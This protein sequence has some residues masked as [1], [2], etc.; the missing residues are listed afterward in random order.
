MVTVTRK[1]ERFYVPTSRIGS[2]IDAISMIARPKSF[3]TDY[4]E[5]LYLNNAEHEVPFG[6]SIKARRYS[7]MHWDSQVQLD[8]NT[9]WL[10]E[11][12]RELVSGSS[13]LREKEREKLILS[14]ILEK[15]KT[16]NR[17]GNVPVTSPLVPY[18]ADN[19]RRRHFE[20][21]G[22][23]EF[24]ITVDDALKYFFF[25]SGLNG[26][27]I[28]KEDYS[29]VEIK[30]PKEKMGSLEL[31][32]IQSQLDKLEAEPVISKKDMAHN[33]LSDYLR[34]KSN[35]PVN[36]SDTEI[37]SKLILGDESQHVFHQIKR[38]FH[39]GVIDGYSILE[40]FPFTLEA[41][42]LH[43]YVITPD[44]RYLRISMKGDKKKVISKTDSEI[45]E[46]SYGLNCILK[47]TEVREEFSPD[48]LSLPSR[49]I[50]RK[51]KYFLVE[52]K[53]TG[54]TYC[55]LIDRSTLDGQTMFQMEVEGT[56]LSPSPSEVKATVE[57][58]AY[59]TKSIVNRY[60]NL[61]PTTLAKLD[62]LRKTLLL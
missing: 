59:L 23:D 20:V 26:T 52:N 41:G 4:N 34:R 43:R 5:T 11:M 60:D 53:K 55:V 21:I 19:Y 27:Q 10:F 15:M 14:Q 3:Q 48:V 33:L 31:Q 62:W 16:L 9:E 22:A 32:K 39:D 49:T 45:M 58:I 6:I 30:V 40:G 35:R 61:T 29:R 25:E 1:E 7:D 38:D 36:P 57:D 54:E 44:G 47:R 28:G 56:L 2:F 42:K 46:N 8:I 12:K 24:R 18:V 13:L 17:I 51:R 50:Y 37:E